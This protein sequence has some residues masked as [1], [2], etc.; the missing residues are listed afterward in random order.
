MFTGKNENIYV[1]MLF[2]NENE[3]ELGINYTSI[4]QHI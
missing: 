2:I 3:W 1:E 4:R